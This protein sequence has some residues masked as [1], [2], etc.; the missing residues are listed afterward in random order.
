M[1]LARSVLKILQSGGLLKLEKLFREI[2]DGL[3]QK[4]RIA[5]ELEAVGRQYQGI[6]TPAKRSLAR[7]TR[8][9]ISFNER[10]LQGGR[11]KAGLRSGIPI[12]EGARFNDTNSA[13][14]KY[15]FAGIL[16]NEETGESKPVT[17]NILSNTAL[18]LDELK[19]L[20]EEKIATNLTGSPGLAKFL[21]ADSPRIETVLR[22]LA[23]RNH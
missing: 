20:V 4:E 2:P 6:T 17:V 7:L 21:A 22:V 3:G 18:T 5:A 16:G 15:S 8:D 1:A 14:I 9:A 10:I 13:G 23:I 12:A 11:S 19:K